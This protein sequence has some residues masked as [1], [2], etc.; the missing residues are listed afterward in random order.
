LNSEGI[1]TKEAYSTMSN[2][3]SA[4]KPLYLAYTNGVIISLGVG[5]EVRHGEFLGDVPPYFGGQSR[6]LNSSWGFM[7]ILEMRKET[8]EFLDQTTGMIFDMYAQ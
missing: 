3:K 6:N 2:A 8:S 1:N 4:S 5:K 7:K